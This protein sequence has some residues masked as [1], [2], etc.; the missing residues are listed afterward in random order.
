MDRMVAKDAL[1]RTRAENLRFLLDLTNRTLPRI[2]NA[3]MS[4]LGVDIVLGALLAG[5][6]GKTRDEFLS[7]MGL[8]ISPEG[9]AEAYCSALTRMFPGLGLAN[10]IVVKRGFDL[11]KD[12]LTF[13]VDKMNAVVGQVDLQDP[14]TVIGINE[15]VSKRTRGKILSLIDSLDPMA[16]M[17]AINATQFVRGWK[18][19]FEDAQPGPF[20]NADGKVV[21][22]QM[23]TKSSNLFRGVL[24][25]EGVCR[26]AALPYD[27]T[28]EDDEGSDTVMVLL[29]PNDDGPT[30]VEECLEALDSETWI[31]LLDHLSK[32]GSDKVHITM[33]RFEI[34]SSYQ[35]TQITDALKR[36]GL[37]SAFNFDTAD[38]SKMIGADE[39]ICLSRVAQA[40]FIK[41]D[42][43]GTEAAAGTFAE[44][45]YRGASVQGDEIV[46]DRP[47]AFL[48]ADPKVKVP[49]FV[50]V[51]RDPT[52]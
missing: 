11:Q 39:D 51:V 49:S 14:D 15:W 50:G 33:P 13:V 45:V 24:E 40:A 1:D 41:V 2:G 12:Y 34:R 44:I 3:V 10:L 30:S 27:L 7:V 18:M 38:F 20:T 43:Q 37:V 21:T 29:L 6:A 26:C 17:V 47:F 8:P 19:P 46:L 42:E 4:P 52:R 23:M 31:D 32:E 48:I 36:M 22:A 9:T 16:I 28:G 25:I 5:T 35:S